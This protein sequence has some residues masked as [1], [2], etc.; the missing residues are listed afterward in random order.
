MI[1]EAVVFPVVLEDAA[2]IYAEASGIGHASLAFAC[3]GQ[4]VA[5]L[6]FL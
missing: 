1:W 2:G 5:L 4:W 3:I 6:L